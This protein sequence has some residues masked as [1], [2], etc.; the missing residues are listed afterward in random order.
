MEESGLKVLLTLLH[1]IVL[2]ACY[3]HLELHQE[4]LIPKIKGRAIVL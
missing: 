3:F 2:L 1:K 4:V